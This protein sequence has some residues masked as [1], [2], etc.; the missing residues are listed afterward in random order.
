MPIR[1]G[2]R[3]WPSSADSRAVEHQ[4]H[5]R[6][7]QEQQHRQHLLPTPRRP[8]PRV[9]D[10]SNRDQASRASPR[11]HKSLSRLDPPHPQ[12]EKEMAQSDHAQ[13][14][15]PLRQIDRVPRKTQRHGRT[16]RSGRFSVSRCNRANPATHTATRLHTLRA[17]GKTS[18][19]TSRADLLHCS[20]LKCS[21]APSLRPRRRHRQARS[22]NTSSHVSSAPLERRGRRESQEQRTQRVLSSRR[23]SGCV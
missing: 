7:V 1:F 2:P 6:Q 15:P 21:M 14:K 22:S 18:R 5:P 20:L 16:K 17:R 8:T 4:Q 9:A 13:H 19:V 11:R 12:S 10:L 3:D 23:R